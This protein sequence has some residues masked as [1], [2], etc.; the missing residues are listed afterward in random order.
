V[1]RKGLSGLPIGPV[2]IFIVGIIVVLYILTKSM[3]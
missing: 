1:A 3:Y 2:L